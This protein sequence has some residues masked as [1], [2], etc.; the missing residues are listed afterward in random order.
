MTGIALRLQI[1]YR[2]STLRDDR[3]RTEPSST[4][5]DQG[6]AMSVLDSIT[7]DQASFDLTASRPT[8]IRVVSPRVPFSMP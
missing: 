3:E 6:S 5:V 7:G 8:M 1:K 4:I 2:V